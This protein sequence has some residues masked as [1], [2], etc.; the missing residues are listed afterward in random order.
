MS[1][2][3]TV[4]RW[5]KALRTLR[6]LEQHH[7]KLAELLKF[8]PSLATESCPTAS[9]AIP[10]PTLASEHPS[11]NLS[12]ARDGSPYHHIPPPIQ[13][14]HRD[15][16]SSIAS[17]LASARGIPSNRQRRSIQPL[18]VV[19][20]QH[21]EGRV[22]NPSR[23]TRQADS[24]VNNTLGV[25]KD[26]THSALQSTVSPA[27]V[28]LPELTSKHAKEDT[29]S[30]S[31]N[32]EPFQRFYATFEGLLSKLSAPL[33]FAGLPLSQ[34][35]VPI[36]SSLTSKQKNEERVTADPDV[37]QLFSK[38][39]L[40]AVRDEHGPGGGGF[41]GA[42]SF[43]VVPTTGGT[44][45]Y[46]GILSRAEREAR[47]AAIDED[48]GDDDFVD[49]RETPQ[50]IS[51]GL[52]RRDNRPK[53]KTMEELLLENKTLRLYVD[54]ISKRLQTFE[55]GAQSSSMA[56]HMSMRA[57]QSPTASGAGHGGPN[58]EERLK[59]LEEQVANSQTEFEKLKKENEKLKAILGR[60][61]DKWEKLKQG[62]RGRID[63]TG[64]D[65][66]RKE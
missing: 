56:L 66:G 32:D 21:A 52:R 7:Q 17:N 11:Q 18:P 34:D 10:S 43:Y 4:N 39:A 8:R 53:G 30:P 45:S 37:S 41:G 49:A 51:P 24:E 46:A 57:L 58:Q 12:N 3:H 1:N 6:L 5:Y 31:R 2:R 42:E 44:V 25:E 20:P 63:V 35:E 55:M 60:Y 62:A 65:D 59:A 36:R 9:Q 14:P 16:S 13:L 38:A 15:L 33:A 50:P 48:P 47:L 23:K 40:K 27:Q 64:K 26:K 19:S 61:R 29:Q 54:D 22:L 28:P